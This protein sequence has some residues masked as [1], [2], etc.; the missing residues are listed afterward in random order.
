MNEKPNFGFSELSGGRMLS[1]KEAALEIGLG[2]E[3]LCIG[4]PRERSMQ[5]SRLSLTPDAVEILVNNGHEVVVETEA[6]KAAHFPDNLYSD[7]GAKIAYS[8]KEVFK[9]NLVLKVEPPTMREVEMLE[10][11]ATLISALQ[12]TNVSKEYLSALKDRKVTALAYELIQDRVGGTPL[13]RAMSEIAGCSVVQIAGECLS[14]AGTGKGVLLGGITGVAPA[15]VVILGGGTVAEFASRAALGLG[16][17]V[18]VFDNDIYKLRR[19]KNIL[20]APVS[21]STLDTRALKATLACA[22]V[23]IGAIKLEMGR[24]RYWVTEEMVAGMQPGTVII[25]VSIDQGGCFETS[26]VTSHDNPY[27]YS[28]EILHYCVPNIPSRVGRTAT[29]AIS[30]ILTPLLLKIGDRGGVDE[31]IFSDKGFMSGVYSYKGCLTNSVLA[32]R[33]NLQFKDLELLMA[34]RF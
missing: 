18:K 26:R 14:G 23:V 17:E 6:G 33:F 9:S 15:K 12:T 5:E 1:P 19:L 25:D 29:R 8:E 30:N 3:S 16:A 2:E 34:A 20:G 22:D 21:T 24:D 10:Q 27:F 4:V 32:R 11:G 31:T 7:A 13:V 28:H